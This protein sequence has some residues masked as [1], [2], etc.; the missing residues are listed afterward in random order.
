MWPTIVSIQLHFPL[1]PIWHVLSPF[2]AGKTHILLNVDIDNWSLYIGKSLASQ[3]MSDSKLT[4]KAPSERTWRAMM[5]LQ[6]AFVPPS[7]QVPLWGTIIV[8]CPCCKSLCVP[9]F[10][11]LQY[12]CYGAPLLCFKCSL[13]VSTIQTRVGA[14]WLCFE[15]AHNICKPCLRGRAIFLR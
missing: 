2:N 6:S 13:M 12:K 1:R 4:N 5:V 8:F 15:G 10:H 14:L 7:P 9:S 11:F 3:S